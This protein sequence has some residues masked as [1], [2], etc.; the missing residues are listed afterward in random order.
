VFNDIHFL[1]IPSFKWHIPKVDNYNVDEDGPAGRLGHSSA[2]YGDKL[3]IFGGHTVHDEISNELFM[4][5]L[6]NMK[7]TNYGLQNSVQ[8]LAY[9]AS[10]VILDDMKLA[11]FGGLT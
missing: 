5:N 3:F 11:V 2:I 1:G 4:L 6:Q 10:T 8:P 7:W 9:A